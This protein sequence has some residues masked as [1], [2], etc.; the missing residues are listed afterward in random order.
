[1]KSN[2]ND[3]QIQILEV[4]ETLAE[5]GFEGTSIRTIAKVAQINVAMV[6]LLWIQRTITGILNCL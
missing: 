2:F 1:L 4:A 3:K 5:K 6:S